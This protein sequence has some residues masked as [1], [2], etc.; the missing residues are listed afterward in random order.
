MKKNL[1]IIAIILILVL[2]ISVI[3]YHKTFVTN[4]NPAAE[5]NVYVTESEFTDNEANR[6]DEII[7]ISLD[8]IRG[9]TQKEAEDL[10]YFVMGE[11]DEDTGFLF[12]FASTGAVERN[13]KQYYV[14]RASWLVNNS[15]MSYIGDFFVSSDGKEI[16]NGIAKPGEYEMTDILWRK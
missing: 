16:Y 14:I 13:K 5:K 1:I 9:I 6:Q 3:L 10:C 7:E 4:N 12:S 15:H 2:A 8:D 11:K